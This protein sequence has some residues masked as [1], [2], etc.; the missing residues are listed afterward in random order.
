VSRRSIGLSTSS[1]H[2]IGSNRWP[3]PQADG[4]PIG[5]FDCVI[6]PPQPLA[7][8]AH[9]SILV[10]NEPQKIPQ[11]LGA[12]SRPPTHC[13]YAIHTHDGSGKIHVTPAAARRRGSK[14]SNGAASSSGIIAR[15]RSR[16]V[17]PSPRAPRPGSLT[18]LRMQS[19]APKCARSSLSRPN[20]LHSCVS[21]ASSQRRTAP[22]NLSFPHCLSP[23]ISCRLCVNH[24]RS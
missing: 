19:S 24:A 3:N 9:L 12:S 2:S 11:Y 17:R 18:Q 20:C 6:N 4:A 21:A 22:S 16:S 5:R 1:G 14:T 8:H 23:G 7:F 13:F 10:N 15:S